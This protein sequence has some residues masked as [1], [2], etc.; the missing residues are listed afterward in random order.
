[1][2]VLLFIS[3]LLM[4]C[5][6]ADTDYCTADS[7]CTSVFTDEYCCA[8]IEA[9]TSSLTESGKNCYNR[10]DIQNNNG[11]FQILDITYKMYCAES[12]MS[13]TMGLMFMVMMVGSEIL[14]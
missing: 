14:L 7:D 8:H 1:M 11:K 13:M 10:L 4:L 12:I 6:K 3:C 5:T 2:K 9:I